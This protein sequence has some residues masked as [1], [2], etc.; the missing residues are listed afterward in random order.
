M[1][2]KIDYTETDSKGLYTASIEGIEEKAEL[3]TS[4]ASN[5]LIIV[6]HT[7]VPDDMRGQGVAGLLMERV[8]ADARAANQKIIP[9]CPV[10]KAYAMK[11]KEELSDVIQ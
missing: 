7:F 6:D 1:D 2:A 11:R 5:A 9:L 4:K 3:S 10:F 8:I